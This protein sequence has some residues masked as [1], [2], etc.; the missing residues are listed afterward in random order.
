M[1]IQH[2]T[3]DRMKQSI[4][5]HVTVPLRTWRTGFWPLIPGAPTST[6]TCT[7]T[8]TSSGSPL[9]H[10]R[11][12]IFVVL[13]CCEVLMVMCFIRR[14]PGSEFLARSD[15]VPDNLSG[16]EAVFLLILVPRTINFTAIFVYYRKQLSRKPFPR[17]F[18]FFFN[19]TYHL[20]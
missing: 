17:K 4:P 8:A 18:I 13:A 7:A 1:Y 2:T 12:P 6:P 20:R 14:S 15:P 11:L 9:F 5:S 10:T 3:V 16:S 19:P